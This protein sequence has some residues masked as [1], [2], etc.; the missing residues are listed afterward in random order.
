MESVEEKAREWLKQV[1]S[2][3]PLAVIGDINIWNRIENRP[4]QIPEVKIQFSIPLE[5][6]M[7]ELPALR[8][9]FKASG[10]IQILALNFQERAILDIIDIL[11]PFSRLILVNSDDLVL[12]QVD[13]YSNIHINNLTLEIV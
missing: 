8:A 4:D 5:S 6:L 13:L 12:T 1:N 2:D 7:E 9:K 10:A 3:L 11:E